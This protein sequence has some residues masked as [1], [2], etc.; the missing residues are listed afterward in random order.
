[1]MAE[2]IDGRD[3]AKHFLSSFFLSIFTNLSCASG[4]SND[5]SHMINGVFT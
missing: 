3:P 1:M 4:Y 2:A 5:T